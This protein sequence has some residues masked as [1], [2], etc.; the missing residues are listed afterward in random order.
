MAKLIHISKVIPIA[1]N[2]KPHNFKFVAKGDKNRDG[3]YIVVM[4]NAVVTSSNN[5][6]Q[7]I[8]IKSLVSGEI[9]WCYYV[10]LIELD[11]IEVII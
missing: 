5:E 6:R 8:N 10:L 1:E 4:N 9:R 2:G 3:G 7:K 11:G